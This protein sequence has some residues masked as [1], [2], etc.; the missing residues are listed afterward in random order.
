M[1][2]Y[3]P[4]ALFVAYVA[5]ALA[6]GGESAWIGTGA[7]V[8]LMLVVRDMGIAVLG[9]TLAAWLPWAWTRGAFW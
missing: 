7:T 8:L 2:S 1:L 5:P 9:G 3:V 6:A 4:G